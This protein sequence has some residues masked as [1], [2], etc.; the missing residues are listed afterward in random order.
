MAYNHE[1]PYTD[2]YR[3]NADWLIHKVKEFGETLDSWKSTIDELVEAL[4]EINEFDNR[5][6]SLE[7]ATADLPEIRA[8]LTQLQASLEDAFSDIAALDSKI[9]NITI[10]YDLVLAELARI[11]G[12]FPTYLKEANDYTDIKVSQSFI[13]TYQYIAEL[14]R[15][16]DELKQL[17]PITLVNPIRGTENGLQSSYNL[18]YADMRDDCLTVAQFSELG[19]TS[20]EFDAYELNN[21]EFS[22]HSRSI[23]K[24]DYVTAPVTG[25]YKSVSHALSELLNFI[26]GSFTVTEFAALD[27]TSDDFDA[28]DY[29]CLD[30]LMANDANR[31]LTVSEFSDIIKSG[32]S[33]I[34]RAE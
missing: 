21:I 33:G 16:I 11:V 7:D 29:S 4:A 9:D 34:L 17:R 24:W 12:L 13:E 15:Q 25:L 27:L 23:F 31:G 2:P 10:D 32:G 20:N 28:L 5:I 3:S 22:L 8:K 6:T 18:A 1:W 14:Q 19:L 26:L 30:F